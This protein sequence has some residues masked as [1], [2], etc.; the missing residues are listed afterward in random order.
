MKFVSAYLAV[1]G[2]LLALDAVWVT[3]L[4]RDLYAGHLGALFAD[5]MRLLIA[6]FYLV[7][8]TVGI[9]VLAVEPAVK[10]GDARRSMKLGALVGLVVFA[11][12]DLVSL[13]ASQG[14]PPSLAVVDGMWD[15]VLGAVAARV[16]YAA[17]V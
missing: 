10:A 14:L 17:V 6:A 11:S 8:L 13:A 7:V 3:F 4:A 5:Q 1:A 2:V 16:G 9:V 12:V 15:V